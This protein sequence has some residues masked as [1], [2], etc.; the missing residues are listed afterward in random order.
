MN[1]FRSAWPGAAK[2]RAALPPSPEY[3]LEGLRSQ[4]LIDATETFLIYHEFAQV[5]EFAIIEDGDEIVFTTTCV[6]DTETLQDRAIVQQQGVYLGSV[7]CF[8]LSNLFAV[9]PRPEQIIYTRRIAPAPEEAIRTGWRILK[10]TD[11]EEMYYLDLDQL[12]A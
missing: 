1:G 5:R 3:A 6:W 7:R 8:I 2:P 12:T 11:A 4:F 10:I 9:E